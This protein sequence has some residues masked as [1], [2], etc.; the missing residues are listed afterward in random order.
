M[1]S[2]KQ[3]AF[4]SSHTHSNWIKHIL[5]K[6]NISSLSILVQLLITS[7]DKLK[8]TFGIMFEYISGYHTA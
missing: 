3:Q 4:Y 6:S 1:Y 7:S 2:K 5:T 8:G